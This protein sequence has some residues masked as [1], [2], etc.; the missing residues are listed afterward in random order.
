MSQLRPT[1][2]LLVLK[3][4]SREEN[5]KKF[6]FEKDI[7]ASLLEAKCEARKGV[8]LDPLSKNYL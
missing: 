5:Q 6:M 1:I 7:I 2:F 8:C 3:R 4:Y